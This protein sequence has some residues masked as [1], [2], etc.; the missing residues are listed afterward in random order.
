L[1]SDVDEQRDKPLD[2]D[3]DDRQDDKDG[4][5]KPPPTNPEKDKTVHGDEELVV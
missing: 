5:R 1:R 4:E 2:H 3:N